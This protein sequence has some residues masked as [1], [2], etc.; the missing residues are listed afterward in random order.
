MT[1]NMTLVTGATGKTG[2]RV[3]E[4]LRERGL[5]VRAGSRSG[6]PRFDW[7]D[8]STWGPALRDVSGVYLVYGPE[9]N[10]PG[11]AETISAFAQEAAGAGVRR[12]VLLSARSHR[13]PV[14]P[15]DRA[16]RAAE[17]AVRG[18]GTEW[19]VLRPSW[20]QQNFSEA[21][22]LR[23][24]VIAGE[25]Q[26]PTGDGRDAFIDVR[27]IAE[28]AVTALTED[29]HAGQVYELTGPRLLSVGDVVA[30]IAG[31]TGRDLRYV[32]V[33]PE[34][35]AAALTGLGVPEDVVELLNELFGHVR[36]GDLETVTE[37]VRKVLGREPRDTAA[38]VRETAATGIWGGSPA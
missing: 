18:G 9:V 13:G 14:G 26:L 37:D 3:A 7:T 4:L 35:Y 6:E 8:R 24:P 12:V 11:A 30:E 21:D 38:Y 25:L 5:P 32:P 15:L 23:D 19:T 36:A 34:E 16:F 22:F 33:T 17:R 10:S 2:S 27:D 29:G 28:V 1:E 20:F 31:A